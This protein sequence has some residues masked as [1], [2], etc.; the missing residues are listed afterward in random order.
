VWDQYSAD[1]VEP[2]RGRLSWSDPNASSAG[3][4][5]YRVAFAAR[6]MHE[7]GPNWKEEPIRRLDVAPDWESTT[8]NHMVAV[9][10]RRE[11]LMTREC[12]E[13]KEDAKCDFAMTSLNVG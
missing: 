3:R 10:A 13:E 2:V 7:A 11:F 5:E 6:T 1:N 8:S 4:G 12:C 9:L